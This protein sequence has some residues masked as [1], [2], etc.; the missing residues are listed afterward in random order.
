[1]K[2]VRPSGYPARFNT[3]RPERSRHSIST[4]K[5]LPLHKVWQPLEVALIMS[6]RGSDLIASFNRIPL[7]DTPFVI[8]FESHLPRLFTYERSAAFRYFTK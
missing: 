3:P 6:S 8:S 2:V 4:R 5:W 7:G 1:L